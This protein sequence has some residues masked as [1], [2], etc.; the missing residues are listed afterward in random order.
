M[1]DAVITAIIMAVSSVVCQI[2]INR[3][4]RIKRRIEDAEKEQAR[5]VQEAVKEAN[6]NNRLASIESKLDEHNG[7]AQKFEA[8]AGKFSEI[9]SDLS[10][11]KTSIDFIKEN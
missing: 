11:I 6:L 7:Y 3:N 5:A 2:L 10:A 1:S 8:V 9:A 4:N